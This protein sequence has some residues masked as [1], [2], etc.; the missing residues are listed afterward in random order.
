MGNFYEDNEDL[1]FYVER[2]IDWAPLVD[3]TEYGF[4]TEDGFKTTEEAVGFYREILE[5]IGGFVADEV[6]PHEAEIDREGVRFENGDAVFPPRLASIFE[7]IK[8]LELH[9]MC[10]PRELGGQNCPIILFSLEGELFARADVSV[11]A[12]HGFHAGI[13]MASLVYSF[14]EGTTRF[15]PASGKILETRFA[16]EIEELRQGLAW[17]SM[18][19]TEPNAGSDMAALRAV[20]ELDEDGTWRV[21]GQKIFITS[22]H[23]KYHYVIARTEKAGAESDPFAGLAGLS[24]FLVK[25][26]DDTPDGTKTWHATV[27]RVEEK[28]GHHGSATVAISFDRTPAQLIGKRGEGFKYMLTLMNNARIGVGF[29]CI[30]LCESALRKARAYAAER[31]SMGKTIDRHEMI[32]DY[33]DEMETDVR[34]LR[35]L[36]VTSAVHQELGQ[37]LELMLKAGVVPEAELESVQRKSRRHRRLARRYTPLLKY[38]AAEKAVEIA[39]RCLQI[40]GGVGYTTEYGAEK[41]LR[42]ALVMPIYEGTSQIQSL[43]AMKDTLTGIMKTPTRF[44]TRL[45]QAKWREV[46]ARDPDERRLAKVQAL[47]LSAQQHLIARTVQ[48]KV[49][50]VKELPITEW[51]EMLKKNWDPKRDFAFAMLHAERLTQLLADEAVLEILYEQSKA[52]PN[53]RVWF[54]AYAERAESRAR[55]LHDQ[56]LHTGQRLLDRLAEQ[57]AAD[58]TRAAS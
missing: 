25:A 23:A 46:S 12:H 44:A 48:D 29:E 3:A 55:W 49:R 39:R 32:A 34:A 30:G 8:G 13:A 27:D 19:I 57:R 11:M 54:E 17:G 52:H 1:R 16:T 21:T 50:S 33:F 58:E 41:L 43:M 28:L 10:L 24:M 6:A 45:A 31:P 37:K 22:G 7:Q 38:L 5:L 15:D 56:I 40:H 47:S 36:A 26:Y 42:D 4:R 53:R 18:D 20:G 14:E 35:A 9:G 51:P 2:G